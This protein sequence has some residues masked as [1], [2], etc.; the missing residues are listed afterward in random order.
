MAVFSD[1]APGGT[2]SFTPARVPEV[3][4]NVPPEGPITADSCGKSTRPRKGVEAVVVPDE[5]VTDA[6]KVET[7]ALTVAVN[8]T[9]CT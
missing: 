6:L 2:T 9:C 1:K 5:A 4:T 3:P 7:V 8:M